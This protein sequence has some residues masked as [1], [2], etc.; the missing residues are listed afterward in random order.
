MIFPAMPGR[1]TLLKK[2]FKNAVATL[3]VI[4]VSSGSYMWSQR[5]MMRHRQRYGF[6]EYNEPPPAL[7]SNGHLMVWKMFV[8]IAGK[9]FS[10]RLHD[11]TIMI[12]DIGAH[13]N[14]PAFLVYVYT[15]K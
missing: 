5:Y 10:R 14:T 13:V 4:F 8:Y 2:S 11:K 3:V 1:D 6:K 15:N 12:A 7:R 9:I